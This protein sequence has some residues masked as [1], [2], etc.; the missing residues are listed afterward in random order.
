MSEI[1]QIPISKFSIKES[2]PRFLYCE[3][4]I[5]LIGENYNGSIIEKDAYEYAKPTIEYLPVCGKFRSGDFLEHEPDEKPLGT[6]LTL[7]DNNYRYEFGDNGL[8]YVV[9]D[10]I[11]YRDYCEKESNKIIKDGIKKTSIEIEIE[12]KTKLDNGKFRIDKF[13]YRCV[14][15]L[16]NK[17][18]EGMEGCHLELKTSP[19][20]KYSKFI[21]TIKF[22]LSSIDNKIKIEREDCIMGKEEIASKFSL[23]AMQLYDVL[24]KEISQIKY[25]ENWYGQAYECCKYWLRDFDGEFVYVYDCEKGIDVK[26]PYSMSGDN[27]VLNFDEIK[28]IKYTPTD[29]EEGTDVEDVETEF[30]KSVKAFKEDF[31][32]KIYSCGTSKMSD[33]FA[34]E[35]E[36]FATKLSEK[37]DSII[38][39]GKEIDT[40]KG[41]LETYKSEI[42][43]KDEYLADFAKKEKEAIAEK[44]ISQYAE[45]LTEEEQETFKSKVH[46]F[47]DMEL[48]KKEIKSFVCDKF[49]D[50]IKGKSTNASF[51]YLGIVDK[52]INQPSKGT[53]WTDYIDEYKNKINN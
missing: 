3:F 26:I 24:Y 51:S 48:F 23:T 40:L 33:E 36:E 27:V 13:N 52:N 47:N 20:E 50:E 30:S 9:V 44:F 18:S 28:R 34:V 38:E 21:E 12:E 31:S 7:L 14:T 11:I 15:I 25:V 37:E 2:D 45:K 41:T 22:N 4:W 10:G 32:E 42:A 43:K 8:E 46:E 49:E 17:I 16:G 29:W 39:F 19:K 35:K 5:S 6:I 53:N 1:L